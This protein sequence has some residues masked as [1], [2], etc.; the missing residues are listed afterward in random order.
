M[1][2]SP[3][4]TLSS[5]LHAGCFRNTDRGGW[6][7]KFNLIRNS[8]TTVA[9]QFF[10]L[11][12]VN[13]ELWHVIVP[14]AWSL[15]FLLRRR[16]RESELTGAFHFHLKINKPGSRD[17]CFRERHLRQ[18][19]VCCVNDNVLPYFLT[20]RRLQVIRVGTIPLSIGA[21]ST[22]STPAKAATNSIRA[23]RQQFSFVIS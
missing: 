18:G 15:S 13:R 21:G 23:T 9:S 8:H 1:Y 16:S 12:L 11:H 6:G 22:L 19:I 17:G 2:L 4:C 20:L 7:W 5:R 10:R 3:Y 14:A